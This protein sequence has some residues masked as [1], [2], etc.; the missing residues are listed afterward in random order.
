[1]PE[2]P[3]IAEWNHR[4]FFTWKFVNLLILV[5]LIGKRR[6]QMQMSGKFQTRVLNGTTNHGIIVVKCR[7][8]QILIGFYWI[9]W[10]QYKKL[11][12]FSCSMIYEKEYWENR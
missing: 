2:R 12:I 10:I 3:Y 1:M 11:H 5:I 8:K 9:K 4:K 6:N 7:M